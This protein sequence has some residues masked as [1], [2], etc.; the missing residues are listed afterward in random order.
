MTIHTY[1]IDLRISGLNKQ[2]FSSQ[3]KLL[4]WSIQDPFIYSFILLFLCVLIS[5]L[6]SSLFSPVFI[7]KHSKVLVY[8]LAGNCLWF[9]IVLYKFLKFYLNAIIYN[10]FSLFAF[11]CVASSLIH[12]LCYNILSWPKS[13]FIYSVKL[14]FRKSNE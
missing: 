13:H 3:C 8:A 14:I 4:H 2:C 11:N 12:F 6:L 7:N 1:I 10:I 9:Y 5:C